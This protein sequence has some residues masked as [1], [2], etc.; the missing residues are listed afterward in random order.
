MR[1]TLTGSDERDWL[2]SIETCRWRVP[3]K[4]KIFSSRLSLSS[5]QLPV[6]SSSILA[7]PLLSSL[8]VSL[9]KGFVLRFFSAGG[10]LK[11][12]THAVFSSCCTVEARRPVSTFAALSS[13]LFSPS[14][15]R[16]YPPLSPLSPSLSRN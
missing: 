6:S 14:P 15:F 2:M 13:P 1:G 3:W 4:S 11:C 12:D 5:L 10:G 16:P 9:D 8:F 7:S